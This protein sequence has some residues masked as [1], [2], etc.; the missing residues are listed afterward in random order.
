MSGGC[1]RRQRDGCGGSCGRNGGRSA[2][3]DGHFQVS[4]GVGK[5]VGICRCR[6]QRRVREVMS[7]VRGLLL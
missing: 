7:G 5:A 2:I 6:V 4:A 1:L 3:R